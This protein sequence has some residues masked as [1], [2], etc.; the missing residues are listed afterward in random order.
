METVLV[1]GSTGH[2][3]VSA[4]MA[5]LKS[6][7]KVLAIVRN[8]ES[9]QKLIRAIGSAEG[10]TLAYA[11]ITSD[12]G[13]REVVQRVRGGELPE[14]QHVYACAG[15]LYGP[16]PLPDLSLEELHRYMNVDFETNF[17]AYRETIRYLHQQ[18]HRSSTWTLCVG[19]Q[20]DLAMLPAP[21]MTQGALYSMATA[22]A[23]D[24]EFTNVR[25]NEVYL[26]LR[27]EVDE[28]AAKNGTVPSSTFASVYEQILSRADIRSSRVRVDN[29]EDMR[30]LKWGKKF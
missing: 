15:G 23:R 22:A 21:A 24:N 7:R 13:V 14:F 11:D 1:V 26:N 6:K 17:F 25:F 20:G 9:A 12:T 29:L 3:G 10:I 28:V 27:V 5:A 30:T 18:D 2:I 4:V 16:P 8:E 19:S